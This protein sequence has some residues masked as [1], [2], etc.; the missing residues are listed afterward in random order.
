MAGP[1]FLRHLIHRAVVQRRTDARSG[2]GEPIPTWAA[3][4]TIDCRLVFKNQRVAAPDQGFM[5]REEYR[6][7]CDQDEDVLEEDRIAS[8]TLKA[9][10]ASVDAGPFSVEE[11][12]LRNST[13]PHHLSFKLE[14]VE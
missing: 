11:R 1:H 4:G 8:V 3:A 12:L 10:G 7:L 9:T 13:G 2:S 5:M 6:L 14:R